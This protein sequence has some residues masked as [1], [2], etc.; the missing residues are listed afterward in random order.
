MLGKRLKAIDMQ[1]KDVSNEYSDIKDAMDKLNRS[2]DQIRE[3]QS[4]TQNTV[5]KV[6]RE[7]IGSLQNR[8]LIGAGS[9]VFGGIGLFLAASTNDTVWEFIQKY[10][11]GLGLG[12]V[13]TASAIL[14]ILSR[15]K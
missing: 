7:E 10:G 9:L 15:Q 8:W 4:D 3:R 2:V 1:F 5:R 6:L 11:T 12:L 14:F 13:V